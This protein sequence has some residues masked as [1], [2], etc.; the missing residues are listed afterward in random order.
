MFEVLNTTQASWM[1]FDSIARAFTN[2][3]R[4]DKLVFGER[5]FFFNKKIYINLTE[6]YYPH[7]NTILTNENL[8]N[9]FHHNDSPTQ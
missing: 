4:T 8:N 2:V 3:L 6:T 7:K 9:H 1:S 5:L